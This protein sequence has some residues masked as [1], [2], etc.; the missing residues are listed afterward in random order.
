MNSFEK[1]EL[2]I[3]VGDTEKKYQLYLKSPEEALMAVNP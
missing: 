1:D 2:E 3:H